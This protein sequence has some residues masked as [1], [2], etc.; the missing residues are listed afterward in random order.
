M[1][2]LTLEAIQGYPALFVV[3]VF[4]GLGVPIPEDIPLIYAGVQ[5]THGSF[6]WG[7]T[8]AVTGTGL[9][10]RDSLAWTIGRLLGQRLFEASWFQRVVSVERIDQ[11]RHLLT[12]RGPMAVLLGRIMVGFRVPM[13]LAAGAAGVPWLRFF[14]WDLLGMMVTVPLLVA[15]GY[16]VG[17]TVLE[18]AGAIT[19]GSAT[20]WA[21]LAVV[22]LGVWSWRRRRA[23]R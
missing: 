23:V 2:P 3:C 7:P 8:L 10:I 4:S 5:I 16:F 13:F 21:I 11:A 19:R 14:V 15:L 17:P 18:L 1:F 6:A 22:G 9:L 20:M 12:D